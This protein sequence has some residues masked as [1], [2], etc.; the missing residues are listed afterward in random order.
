VRQIFDILQDEEAAPHAVLA[1]VVERLF[2][3]IRFESLKDEPD[4][5]LIHCLADLGH[6]IPRWLTDPTEVGPDRVDTVRGELEHF[7]KL[8]DK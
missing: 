8:L 7:Q 5:L 6:N 3:L 2:V 1:M 4:A